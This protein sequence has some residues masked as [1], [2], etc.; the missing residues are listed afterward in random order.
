MKYPPACVMSMPS[1]LRPCRVIGFR[2][3]NATAHVLSRLLLECSLT[4]ICWYNSGGYMVSF[5]TIG[6][7]VCSSK[8]QHSPHSSRIETDTWLTGFPRF[9]PYYSCAPRNNC[10]SC[11]TAKNVR[12]AWGLACHPRWLPILQKQLVALYNIIHVF[13]YP[14]IEWAI[15]AIG[16]IPGKYGTR[17]EMQ[18]GHAR[19]LYHQ[20]PNNFGASCCTGCLSRGVF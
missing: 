16:A 9:S 5:T 20:G 19:G 3:P 10:R 2:S 6:C 17:H 12:S 15:G 13:V 4:L 1:M 18:I 11:R 7:T 14:Y 8:R